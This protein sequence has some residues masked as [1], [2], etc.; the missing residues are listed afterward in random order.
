MR[1]HTPSRST[2]R[3]A[4]VLAVLGVTFLAGPAWAEAQ[5]AS[6]KA[7]CRRITRQVAH[8]VNVAEMADSRGD[9]L[10]LASTLEHIEQLKLRRVE[11]CPWYEEPNWAEIYARQFA[12]L[13]KK[14][15]KAALTYM[16][17]G[18]YPGL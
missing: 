8:F 2:L 6:N 11:L 4:L 17:F 10:W 7:K 9:D 13:V 16:T 14:A 1:N 3:A 18:A 5:N 12:D 15:G